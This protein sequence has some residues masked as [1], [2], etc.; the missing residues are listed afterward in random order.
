MSFNINIPT[1]F[2]YKENLNR[3]KSE[4]AQ[5]ENKGINLQVNFDANKIKQLATNFEQLQISMANLNDS[6]PDALEST[7]EIMTNAG[8]SAISGGIATAIGD[9]SSSLIT[10][11]SSSAVAAESIAG[12]AGAASV[13]NPLITAGLGVALI[14]ATKGLD[15]FIVTT[16]EVRE[17]VNSLSVSI[18]SVKQELNNLY[19]K[20]ELSDTDKEKIEMLED[21]LGVTQTLHRIKQEKLIK[22]ELFGTFFKSGIKQNLN[23][24]DAQIE[25]LNN[26]MFRQIYNPPGG[27][28]E[29][30]KK[31]ILK[32]TKEYLE[33]ILTY[34][35]KINK[36][37]RKI[38]NTK[39]LGFNF[40]GIDEL[41]EK[42]H[43]L[44]NKS[45]LVFDRLAKENNMDLNSF[46][47]KFNLQS[48]S[49]DATTS[50]LQ[51]YNKTIDNVKSSSSLLTQVQQDLIN[52]N[53]IEDSTILELIEKHP[54]YASAITGIN[55]SKETGIALTKTL[56]NEE[57][58]L[59]SNEEN[60]AV[61]AAERKLADLKATNILTAAKATLLNIKL[62]LANS[63]TF[64]DKITNSYK[65]FKDGAKS[66][67]QELNSEEIKRAK[68]ELKKAQQEVEKNK[69]INISDFL[70]S[71]SSKSNY[72]KELPSPLPQEHI[73]ELKEENTLVKSLTYSLEDL[74]RAYSRLNETDFDTITENLKKQQGI[75]HKLANSVRGN[76]LDSFNQLNKQLKTKLKLEDIFKIAGSEDGLQQVIGYNNYDLFLNTISN[77]IKALTNEHNKLLS[78]NTKNAQKRREDLKKEIQLLENLQN[79]IEK[80]INSIF[81]Y[82]NKYYSIAEKLHSNSKKKLEDL[83]KAREENIRIHREKLEQDIEELKKQ[84]KNTLDDMWDEYDQIEQKLNR[85]KKRM[86]EKFQYQNDYLI[87]L[88]KECE[89]QKVL[90]YAKDHNITLSQAQLNILNQQGDLEK[91]KLDRIQKQLEIKMLQDRLDNLNNNKTIQQIGKNS[92]GNWDFV[93]VTNE[94][95]IRQTMLDLKNAQLDMYYFEEELDRQREQSKIS[96][97]EN[98]LNNL[99]THIENTREILEENLQEQYEK[100]EEYN[101]DIKAL[102]NDLKESYTLSWKD[103]FSN[104]QKYCKKIIDAHKS[105]FKARN[106]SYDSSSESSSSSSSGS[107]SSSKSHSIFHKVKNKVKNTWTKVK[108]HVRGFDTGGYTGDWG[109]EG[110]LAILH[111]KE[112]VFNKFD[113]EDLFNNI[114][115]I[116]DN[117]LNLKTI[118]PMSNSSNISNFNN[119]IS[120]SNQ[121]HNHFENINLPNVINFQ[122]FLNEIDNFSN[123][124]IQYTAKNIN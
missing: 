114:S 115:F 28:Y 67:R 96:S 74:Q 41:Q 85:D 26:R 45:K 124:A 93:Y 25:N 69:K 48:K 47:E 37:Q 17:K 16:E 61:K 65:A 63:K 57:K 64:T 39:E 99:R 86:E 1:E 56:L 43:I 89:V 119:T 5:I 92:S 30:P 91:S 117:L 59:A 10:V 21:E 58:K 8:K 68:E 9:I 52:G 7:F 72:S 40:K 111:E 33:E 73:L 80:G 46:M 24:V 11:G 62:A 51:K 112:M 79:N 101:N 116:K 100:L 2:D 102:Q 77:E 36:V 35:D 60:E 122:E 54:T 20:S 81:D 19:S 4:I 14:G 34:Q 78:S 82:S 66:Y 88:E 27:S 49:I 118:T 104:V 97:R 87:G 106:D 12:V 23:T 3:L 103:I 113:T 50:S 71:N 15:D 44:E 31:E 22:R 105:I 108:N 55:N 6:K 109:N 120:P 98:E 84:N 32:K 18:G 123:T 38:S 121:I 95:E 53:K 107:H 83:K 42:S 75:V 110:K 76:I 13:L 29:L 94:E 70:P 90:N